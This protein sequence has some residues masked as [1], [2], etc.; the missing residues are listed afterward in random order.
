MAKDPKKTIEELNEELSHFED[1]VISV[2]ELL[3]Q[4][5]KDAIT[6]I[7]EESAAVSEIF[8]RRL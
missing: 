7:R 8:E 2:A 5:V 1:Q 4:R 6:D 3:S